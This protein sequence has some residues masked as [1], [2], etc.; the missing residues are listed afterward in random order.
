MTYGIS[1]KYNKMAKLAINIYLD[2]NLTSFPIKPKRLASRMGFLIIYYSDLE[3][4]TRELMCKFSYDGFNFPHKSGNNYVRTIYINDLIMS[5]ARREVSVFHEIKHIVNYDCETENEEK[6][7]ENEKLADYF[8]KYMKCP[9]PYLIYKRIAN[10]TDIMSVF[11]TSEEMAINV[12]KGLL[13][14]IKKYDY[15]I[16][17]YELPLLELLVGSE[18][19]YSKFTVIDSVV[20]GGETNKAPKLE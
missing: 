13:A 11:H 10:I 12:R 17:D 7:K 20:K 1:A 5:S 8:A 19:D 16:F 18:L 3:P 2:Y 14:R 6:N 15:D 9:I 4:E